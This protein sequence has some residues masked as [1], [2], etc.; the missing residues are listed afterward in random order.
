MKTGMNEVKKIYKKLIHKPF[1]QAAYL[2][3]QMVAKL[4]FLLATDNCMFGQHQMCLFPNSILHT[5]S[6]LMTHHFF[7]AFCAPTNRINTLPISQ[8]Q[9]LNLIF[10]FWS[11]ICS[12]T[13]CKWYLTSPPF[14]FPSKALVQGIISFS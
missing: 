5:S 8:M 13:A 3:F 7:L 2:H 1:F 6:P 10:P 12:S 11:L 9:G 4:Q 14:V